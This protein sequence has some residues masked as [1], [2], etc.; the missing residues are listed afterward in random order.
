MAR[1]S[2]PSARTSPGV[3]RHD[4]EGWATLEDDD[5]RRYVASW[6]AFRRLE[7]IP[8]LTGPLRGRRS[9][10]IFVAEKR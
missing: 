5:V 7:E 4:V 9:S 6:S 10:A 1:G 8:P 2:W 3:E